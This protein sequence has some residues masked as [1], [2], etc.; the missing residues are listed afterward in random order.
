VY[1]YGRLLLFI[2]GLPLYGVLAIVILTRWQ[3]KNYSADQMVK[4]MAKIPLMFAIIASVQF[5]FIAPTSSAGHSILTA[6]FGM[7][8]M[9][10]EVIRL[11]I[12]LSVL[13]PVQL[14][15]TMSTPFDPIII[16]SDGLN[17]ENFFKRF[18]WFGLAAMAAALFFG[19]LFLE[20]QAVI[21]AFLTKIQVIKPEDKMLLAK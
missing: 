21:Q 13:S 20:L 10:G 9:G 18:F 5:A 6:P 16:E 11:P 19:K 8:E 2:W 17:I 12:W 4:E 1:I 14:N 3:L 7:V 15:S